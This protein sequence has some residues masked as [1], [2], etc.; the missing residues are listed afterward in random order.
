MK[1]KQIQKKLSLNKQTIANIGKEHMAHLN[2][3]N[4]GNG[5]EKGFYTGRQNKCTKQ[6]EKIPTTKCNAITMDGNDC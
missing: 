1:I 3:G 2:G 4:N 6:E 5:L